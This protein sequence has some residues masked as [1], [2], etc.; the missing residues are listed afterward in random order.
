MDP[1]GLRVGEEAEALEPADEMLL[2]L[3]R[4]VLA[5]V[6]CELLLVAHAAHQSA[7]AAVDE[8]LGELLVQR[9]R[10]RVLDLA[11]LAL[12]VHGVLEPARAVRHERPGADMSETC[13]QGIDVAR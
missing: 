3:D 4:A 1:L 10:Q 7:R 5:D 12:P 6:G 9:V 2:D 8:A 11:R 13:R